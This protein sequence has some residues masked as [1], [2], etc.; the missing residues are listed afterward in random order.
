MKPKTILTILCID[1]VAMILLVLMTQGCVMLK[2]VLQA[3][4]DDLLVETGFYFSIILKLTLVDSLAF[5][6]VPVFSVI[7]LWILSRLDVGT[8]KA[9]VIILNAIAFC[10]SGLSVYY[11]LFFFGNETILFP[12][13]L[14][15]FPPNIACVALIHILFA[16]LFRAFLNSSDNHAAKC[17][18]SSTVKSY[19]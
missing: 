17:I 5:Y 19:E 8:R 15:S 18:P 10:V 6:C 14:L 16:L 12:Q 1:I 2:T 11:A 7:L 3:Q 13:D 9:R 4:F